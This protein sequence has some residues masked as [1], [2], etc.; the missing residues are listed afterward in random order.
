MKRILVIAAG[1]LLAT[2]A[3]GQKFIDDVVLSLENSTEGIYAKGDT[4]KIFAES[5]EMKDAVFQVYINGKVQENYPASI[6]A[7]KS[8]V[9]RAV[10]DEPTALMLRVNNP[11][12]KDDNTMIGAIVAPEEFQPGFEEPADFKAFWDNELK[13]MR[14]MKMKVKLVPVE[15]P[16]RDRGKIECWHLE[17]NC[18]GGSPV[19]AYLAIPV[20][21]KPGTLPI[22]VSL[23][24]AGKITKPTVRSNLK[25]AVKMAKYGDGAIGLDIN[26][27]GMRD[28]ADESYYEE[29][30]KS[31]GGYASKLIT[32]HEDYFFRGM[33]LRLARALDYLCGRPEWDGKRVMVTGGS[34]G[35]AQSA[36][37]AGL[38]SRVTHVVVRVPAMWDMGGKLAD[39]SSA[40]PKPLERNKDNPEAVKIAAYYDASNF[41]RYFTGKL[42]VNVGLIDTTC[43]PA[44]V[45]SVFNVC[46]AASKEIHACPWLG[47]GKYSLPAE[48]GKDV[49]KGMDRRMENACKTFMQE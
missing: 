12:N 21:A 16:E 18:V 13:K 40:W 1:M 30:Q 42:Y 20:D 3:W 10:Y 32:S 14:K 5:A 8:E 26:A 49:K 37:I 7:G 33:F 35:G 2:A 48:K 38:D 36:A 22:C 23:H 47:H 6:P 25:M 17:I 29:L 31:I 15:A 39:R 46:P 45:W 19:M 27:I 11:E 43:P 28:D 24:S 41:M 44:S 4:I 34:Q 9:F